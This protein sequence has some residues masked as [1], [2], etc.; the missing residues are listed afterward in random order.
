MPELNHET[1]GRRAALCI[2]TT[3]S[4]SVTLTPGS[5]RGTEGYCGYDKHVSYM[6]EGTA[7]L[8]DQ[9]KEDQVILITPMMLKGT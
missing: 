4:T 5:L 7:W 2:A 9:S 1:R 6:C 8:S 3:P